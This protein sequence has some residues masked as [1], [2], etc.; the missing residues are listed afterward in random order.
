MPLGHHLGRGWLTACSTSHSRTAQSAER[1]AGFKGR[2]VLRISSTLDLHDNQKA[3]LN[4]LSGKLDAQHVQLTG[5]G[6]VTRAD[7]AS[8]LASEYF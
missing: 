3:K 5:A 2:V 7:L 4:V 8:L 6:A 1:G